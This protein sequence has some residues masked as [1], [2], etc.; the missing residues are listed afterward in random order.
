MLEE[1]GGMTAAGVASQGT[2]VYRLF[3]GNDQLLYVGI[4]N[5]VSRR[6]QQ[7]KERK[8]WWSE[9][10]RQEVAWFATRHEAAAEEQRAIRVEKPQ[11]NVKHNEAPVVTY[12][13]AVRSFDHHDLAALATYPALR[14]ALNDFA[15]EADVGLAVFLGAVQDMALT[16]PFADCCP[17]CRQAPEYLDPAGDGSYLQQTWPH[18]VERNGGWLKCSY[19]CSRCSITWRCGYSVRSAG[20]A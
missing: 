1:D 10:E 5:D 16:A 14:R 9:V 3:A 18:A 11:Y 19:R 6:M 12:Q 4:T 2:A 17:R 15:N 8:P 13:S 20:W 7:H